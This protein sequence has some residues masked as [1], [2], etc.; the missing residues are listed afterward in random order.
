MASD[1]IGGI[2]FEVKVDEQGAQKGLETFDKAMGKTTN[3]AQ[4]AEKEVK[5][6]EQGI[7]VAGAAIATSVG[8]AVVKLGKMMV[9]ATKEIEQG[10]ST[11]VK[12]TGATGSA[13]DGLM[14]S[15]KAVYS[16]TEE[17]FDDVSR[18]I[19]E[20]NTRLGLTGKQLEDTTGLF[21]DFADV[22]DQDVQQSIVDVTQ[23]INKWNLDASDIPAV[24]DK[25]TY[26]GQASGI[27]VSTLTNNLT[28]NAGTLQAL[29]YSMDDA[30]AMMMQF[31]KQGID[32]SSVIMAMKKSFEDSANAG[33]D[34]REDWDNL[35]DSIA[36][37]TDET[38]ANE[39]AIKA[40]GSRVATDMVTALRSGSL[41]FDDYSEAIASAGGTLERTDRASK[42]AMDRFQ[43]FKNK[44]NSMLGSIGEGLV[45]LFFAPKTATDELASAIDTLNI[46]LD[47]YRTITNKLS[48]DV[49]TLTEAERALLEI[50]QRRAK[51]EIAKNLK[52][53]AQ[54]F[55]QTTEAVGEINSAYDTQK[56]RL[57]A[58]NKLILAL[59][60][61]SLKS[62]RDEL[63]QL[64]NKAEEGIL[65]DVEKEVM[66]MYN[67]YLPDLQQALKAGKKEVDYWLDA[68]AEFSSELKEDLIDA[69]TEA[70]NVNADYEETILKL[71]AAV[72]EGI[73]DLET[74][75]DIYPELVAKISETVGALSEENEALADN[76]EGLDGTANETN[77]AIKASQEWIDLLK[78]QADAHEQ[79]VADEMEAEGNILGAYEKRLEI[80]D[81]TVNEELELIRDKVAKNEASEDDLT[82]AQKYFANERGAIIKEM[83]KKILSESAKARQKE[84]D[85]TKKAEDKL[86]EMRE[87]S[88]ESWL[89]KLRQQNVQ[90][91]ENLAA[92]LEG[93]GDIESAYAIREQIIQDEWD[94]EK[95]ILEEKISRNEANASDLAILDKYYGNM[96]RQNNQAKNDAIRAQEEKLAEEEK[97]LAEEAAQ[98]QLDEEKNLANER[99]KI[100]EELTKTLESQQEELEQARAS[101]FEAEGKLAE[102][103]EIRARLI[104]EEMNRE[105]EAM[106]KL[107]D[108]NKA[109]E[110]D[111]AKIKEIYANKQEQINKKKVAAIEKQEEE[112]SKKI[113]TYI[114]N[115]VDT[116]VNMANDIVSILQDV[117]SNFEKELEIMNKAREE[118]IQKYSDQS[119]EKVAILDEEHEQGLISD[120]EYRDKKKQ[121]EDDLAAYTK[122]RT[123][124]DEQAEMELKKKVNE[125]DEKAFRARKATS[126]AKAVIDGASAIMQGFAQL[127]PIAGAVAA[128]LMTGITAAQIAVISG[129]EY[130]PSYAI[131][132][133]Y[134]PEDQLALLHKGEMVLT[135]Q[136]ATRFRDI[137][138]LYALEQTASAPIAANYD[139][140][141]PM[142]INNNLSAVLE[143][144]GTQLG[145]AVLK[146]IDNASTFVLR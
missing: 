102:A 32:S 83:W 141:A 79:S 104:E 49:D 110:E 10:K 122:Q 109:T 54:A 137:G 3:T 82:N 84:E 59:S 100:A 107:V 76:G 28:A 138:G 120:E 113:K 38:E 129:E 4:K 29:G 142:N 96:I 111:I 17:S 74:Y 58:T 135:K 90:I 121:I 25:L 93:T 133:E 115:T 106:Q 116:F 119:D 16:Q 68:L 37:A 21:L 80:F 50:E 35:L 60:K 18:A 126:I 94:K 41:S 47:T 61:G 43:E 39:K 75:K 24:L 2:T 19:G 73:L 31:E 30:I 77:K 23:A 69:E 128:A 40:F 130:V 127:G 86:A 118:D 20:V 70:I 44:I 53:V 56:G 46:S 7:S 114:K 139:R 95:A 88:S 9:E 11:I 146:N 97:R 112:L 6:A 55:R 51:A 27:S 42:T 123:K 48:T 1:I 71:A 62:I 12:A 78:K 103:Y 125:A 105:I 64:Q 143:V 134:I 8:A 13:L 34:A 124:Q 131:G 72:K 101:E 81:K 145:V 117:T 98:K 5:K 63:S 26:A 14:S 136:E 89:S 36:N 85:E 22:T 132:S 91:R 140:L 33:T 65:T 87:A 92:H 15:A 66:A 57:E 45:E 67:R 52:E 108:E 99:T 144:D